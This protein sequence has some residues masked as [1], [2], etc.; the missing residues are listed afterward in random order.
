MKIEGKMKRKKNVNIKTV[1]FILFSII[2]EN[3]IFAQNAINAEFELITEFPG[4]STEKLFSFYTNDYESYAPLGPLVDNKGNLIFFN[5]Q[6]EMIVFNGKTFAKKETEDAHTNSIAYMIA[7]SS[8]CISI[9]QSKMIYTYKNGECKLYELSDDKEYPVQYV[10]FDNA[11]LFIEGKI[12]ESFIV[13]FENQKNEI[14]SYSNISEWLEKHNY[15]LRGTNIFFNN[16]LYASFSEEW[17]KD[18]LIYGRLKNNFVI[19]PDEN[20]NSPSKFIV[21]TFDGN[22]QL[23]LNMNYSLAKNCDNFIV[24]WGI[25]NYGEIYILQGPDLPNHT[26]NYKSGYGNV[27]LYVVRNHL[28]NYGFLNDDRIRLRKGP[29]TN[30]ESLGT[31]PI[32]TG[33]RILEKSGVKQNIGGVTDEWIK[34][35]LPD[36]TEGYFFGQYVQNLYDGPRTSLPWPNVADWN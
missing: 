23:T 6:D 33:F 36:G 20:Q 22:D 21:Q 15:E 2:I 25:G 10:L 18:N 24:S 12:N 16:Q 26:R 7:V 27:K 3:P 34:V 11:V 13:S 19:I 1:L 30:T 14:I 28:K 29:G 17:F 8:N 9:N 32:N 4:N 35:R 31:Y 5:A